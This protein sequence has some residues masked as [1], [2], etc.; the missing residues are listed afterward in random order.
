MDFFRGVAGGGGGGVF[1]GGAAT[2]F[3][4]DVVAQER[5]PT[6]FDGLDGFEGGQI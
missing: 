1:G 3:F 5:R 6:S 4:A 2:R